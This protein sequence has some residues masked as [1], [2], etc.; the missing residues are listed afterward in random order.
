MRFRHFVTLGA[1]LLVLAGIDAAHASPLGSHPTRTHWKTPN[2]TT[3]APSAQYSFAAT[4]TDEA[5]N[6]L[7]V[8]DASGHGHDLTVRTAQGGKIRLVLDEDRPR[9]R[10]PEPCEGWH[11]CPHAVLRSSPNANHLNPGNQRIRFGVTMRMTAEETAEGSNLLQKGYSLTGNQYK[12]Q[13]DGKEGKPSCVLVG[14]SGPIWYALSRVSVA[15]GTWHKVECLREGSSLSV[16]V[17]GTVTGHIAVPEEL[18]I[19][20]SDPLSLGGKGTSIDNDQY[21]GELAEAFVAIG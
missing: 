12:L 21:F 13:V 18:F 1:L 6:A 10:F 14:S 15:D 20:N 5:G 9:I 4:T 19:E 2:A 17:D 3:S 11:Q 16:F 8:P 7:T